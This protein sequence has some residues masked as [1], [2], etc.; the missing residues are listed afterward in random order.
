M[1]DGESIT[2][3]RTV[4]SDA[5]GNVGLEDGVDWHWN[6]LLSGAALS[7]LVGIG[8]ELAQPDDQAN[9]DRNLV[10]AQRSS[11]DTVNQVGQEITRRNLDIQSTLTI[12]HAH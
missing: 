5:A 1:P 8:A 3:D 11:Q 4:A 12:R 10:A 9:S 2:L 7:T 6:R